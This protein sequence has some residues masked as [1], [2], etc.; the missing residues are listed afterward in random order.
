M[1]NT[2]HTISLKILLQCRIGRR[3]VVRLS[4]VARETNPGSVSRAHTH[5]AGSLVGSSTSISPNQ[6]HEGGDHTVRYGF[7]VYSRE[8]GYLL[9]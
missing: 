4:R 2:A 7:F 6:Q 5:S 9:K 1:R 8:R 3:A